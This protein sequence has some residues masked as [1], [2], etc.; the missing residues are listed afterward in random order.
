MRDRKG[1]ICK[2][3][4]AGDRAAGGCARRKPGCK[5]VEPREAHVRAP[6]LALRGVKVHRGGRLVLDVE[7]L[8]LRRGELVL[9]SGENG[10]GKTTLLLAAAG[11]VD[12]SEG[13]VEMEGKPFHTGRAPAPVQARRRIGFVQQ[14]PYMFSGSVLENTSYGLC[15]RGEPQKARN[16]R[17]RQMLESLGIGHLAERDAR[18]LS[19][20]EQKLVAFA[21]AVVLDCPVLLLDEVTAS[22]DEKAREKVI[23]SVREQAYGLG[24]A[25]LM[26][27]HIDYQAPGL[28]C[29]PVR[30][31]SGRLI[32]G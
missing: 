5:R 15:L 29:R 12:L 11:L 32:P 26:A 6:Y 4:G 19:V 20:G 7:S 31:A 9:L 23:E 16:E 3:G 24:K 30:I 14:S 27:S 17:A 1:R 28:E 22:L 10:A 25:V 2:R 13:V 8:E 18:E 21:R